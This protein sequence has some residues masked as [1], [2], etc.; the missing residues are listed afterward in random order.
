MEFR[1][2]IFRSQPEYHDAAI[3]KG[4]HKIEE[5]TGIP[6]MDF[7]HAR[8]T[9]ADWARTICRFSKD[10]V[11]LAMNHVDKRNK[12]TDIYISANWDIVDEV[13]EGTISLLRLNPSRKINN[14]TGTRNTCSIRAA[15]LTSTV[16]VTALQ[17][18]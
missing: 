2:V 7:Y 17:R 5:I 12:T 14:Q 16:N 1:R 18:S 3:S 10:D 6:N 9:F 11:A 4:M 15:I 13:P 8:H